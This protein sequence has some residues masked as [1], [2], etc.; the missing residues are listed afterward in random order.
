[1]AN[2]EAERM[3]VDASPAAAALHE[4]APGVHA[5]VQPDGT[6]WINNAGAIAAVGDDGT[7]PGGT[8]IVDTCATF[9][10]T[11]RFLAAVAVATGS[12]PIAMAVNTHQHGD[13]AYGNSL[14]PRE[15]V[16]IGHA[17]MRAGLLADTIIDACPPVWSPVPE[18]GPVSRR[19]PTI[20]VA[21]R[22]IIYAGTRVVSLHH[23][24]HAA[25]TTGDLVAWLPAERVLFSGDL[26]FHG[27]TPLVMM[28]SVSGARRSLEWLASFDAIV[29][30]PGHGP[31]VDSAAIAGVLD[32]HD[33]YY[34]FV[35]SV[36][37]D[38]RRHGLSPLEAARQCD[39]GEFSAWADSERL[40]LNLHRAYAD[41]EGSD[42]DLL[43]AI[44]DAMQYHGG[45]LPTRVCWAAPSQPQTNWAARAADGELGDQQRTT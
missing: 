40:V 33:R 22:L 35:E 28:G 20:E 7:H 39:L 43:A 25:H 27:L 38:A 36:A 31:L 34:R 24:G 16:V 19:V 17:A 3:D 32:A 26:I 18:W 42:V 1:V 14:L 21:D 9:E 44:V 45:P 41:A 12:A 13:H 10:R 15:T 23:P 6:W 5:W 29:L 11:Q 2:D 4:V 37:A 8:V 30:V